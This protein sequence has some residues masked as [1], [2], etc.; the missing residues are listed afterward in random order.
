MS[1][2]IRIRTTATLALLAVLSACGKNPPMSAAPPTAEPAAKASIDTP[3]PTLDIPYTDGAGRRQTLDI[4]GVT[5]ARGLPVMVYVHGGGWHKG[6]KSRV[7][8]KPDAFARAGWIFV[9]VN[10]RL[11][12]DKPDPEGQAQDVARAV[13]WVAKHIHNYG[14]DPQRIALMGHSAG[15]HLAALAVLAPEYGL[16]PGDVDGVLLLDSAGYD[17]NYQLDELM[18]SARGRRL[19]LQVFGNDP[20]IRRRLSPTQRVGDAGT[21]PPFLIYH[22]ERN[23]R[24][25][26]QSQRLVDALRKAGGEAEIHA[27]AHSHASINR[28]FGAE[29]ETV[30]ARSMQWLSEIVGTDR[31]D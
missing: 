27:A 18:P 9:S 21:P 1:S 19:F 24:S 5:A 10:Y 12:A 4:Y 20:E 26:A 28:Q 22:I 6:D 8:L 31:D 23:R 14:G 11:D 15:A 13:S 25:A 16:Q 17:I 30:T 3:T 7:W 2:P 29:G